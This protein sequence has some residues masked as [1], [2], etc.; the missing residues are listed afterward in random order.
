M[1]EIVRNQL[2]EEPQNTSNEKG[3]NNW[4]QEIYEGQVNHTVPSFY[5]CNNPVERKLREATL[6]YF[7][8]NRKMLEEAG[9]GNGN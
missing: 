1:A 7:E 6:K 3:G 4:P 2:S 5:D 8:L 9:A